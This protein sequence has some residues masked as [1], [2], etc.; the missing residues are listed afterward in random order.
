MKTESLLE[1]FLPKEFQVYFDFINIEEDGDNRLLLHLDEKPI[2]PFAH[3]DKELVSNGFD[4]PVQIQDFPIRDKSVYFI[5]R[6]RKW[7]DKQTGK[8]YSTNW[9]FTAN[10]TSYTKE[11]ADFLKEFLR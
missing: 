9:D 3:S 10:G 6:R 5:I 11:F 1:Y 7:L 4:E 2:K 8:V